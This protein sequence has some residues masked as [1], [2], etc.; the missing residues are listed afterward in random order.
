M[1]LA[2]CACGRRLFVTHA[3]DG[4]KIYG[5]PKGHVTASGVANFPIRLK[6]GVK[7]KRGTRRRQE[8]ARRAIGG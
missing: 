6:L 7:Q 4:H 2:R 1:P 8:R 5:C 3:I